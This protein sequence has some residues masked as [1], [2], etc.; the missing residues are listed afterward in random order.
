MI[1]EQLK[2][3]EQSDMYPFHMPGHKRNMACE[4]DIFGIDITEIDDFDNLHHPT[5]MIQEAQERAARLY[6]AEKTYFVINGSTAGLLAGISAC[7]KKGGRILM[8]RNCHKAV[9]NAVFLRDLKPVYLYPETDPLYGINGGIC[10][11]E[12][13]RQLECFADVQLVVITS[14]TYEGIVSDVKKIA[15]ICQAHHVPLLVD[16]AHGAHFGLADHEK[17]YKNAIQNGA[18]VVIHSIHKTLPA[19]TQTA[20]L[21]V[22]SGLV[23]EEKVRKYLSIYQTSSPSYVLMAYMDNCMQ[24]LE[25]QGRKLF[26]DYFKRIDNVRKEAFSHIRIMGEELIGT[27]AIA[28]VDTGKLAISCAGTDKTGRQ[29]YDYLREKHHLQ[30]EMAAGSYALAMTSVMDTEEGFARLIRGLH[31]FDA[32]CDPANRQV[33]TEYPIQPKQFYSVSEAEEMPVKTV[34]LLESE[35]MAAADYVYLYPPGIPLIVP[36]EQI[37]PE[38]LEKIA[39]C[40]QCGL[41]IEGLVGEDGGYI[42]VLVDN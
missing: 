15:S 36:G 38:W 37:C 8:A 14:P 34:K 39:G 42:R 7:T 31:E 13:E 40:R 18:D 23:Q 27:C 4:A 32:L 26:D 9:Y 1:L 22:N 30:L 5:G 2:S 35:G 29:L 12:V 10:P 41:T 19:P 3:L 6:H 25:K 17:L 33:S 28:G 24:I 16:E 20:L 11:E 21:H